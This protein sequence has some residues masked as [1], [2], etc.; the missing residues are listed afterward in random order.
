MTTVKFQSPDY[1]P[2][3]GFTYSVIA[4]R[5]NDKWIFVRHHDRTT[6][7]IAG[8]HIEPDETPL[9]TAWRELAEETGALD[10][11]LECIASYSVEKD[12]ATGYGRLFY[13][14]ITEISTIPCTSE[15][16]EIVMMDRLPDNLTYPDIQPRLFNKVVEYFQGR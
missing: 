2:A 5:Y 7:E 4:A 1:I 10:F 15:I 14:D 13:A 9:D 11:T 3:S 16:E 6:L 8:G 12:G